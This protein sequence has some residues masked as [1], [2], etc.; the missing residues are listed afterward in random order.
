MGR[1]VN[2]LGI[3]YIVCGGVNLLLGS[4]LLVLGVGAAVIV[5]GDA[6][7]G[8]GVAGGLIVAAFF[9][10]AIIALVWGAANL[11]AGR[12]IRRHQSNARLACLVLAVLNLFVLPFG[13]AL[14]LYALWVLLDNNARALFENETA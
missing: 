12:A 4:S 3:L 5:S 10:V 6:A 11:W 8:G 2:L 1:H 13:T 14:G 7:Y 9:I